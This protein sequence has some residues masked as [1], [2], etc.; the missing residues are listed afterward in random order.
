MPDLCVTK[1][2]H[3]TSAQKYKQE[4]YVQ[5]EGFHDLQEMQNIP[6]VCSGHVFVVKYCMGIKL[7]NIIT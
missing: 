2:E 6:E 5:R 4:V 1:L 7:K 3:L